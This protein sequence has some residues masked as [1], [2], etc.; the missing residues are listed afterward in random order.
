MDPAAVY[1]KT[2][3]GR[4]EMRV[5][6]LALPAR[7]RALLIA[8]DG[9]HSAAALARQFPG[10][11][12]IGAALTQ[13]H[14]LGLVEPA[15]GSQAPRVALP[16][17]SAIQAPQLEAIADVAGERLERAVAFLETA[18]RERMGRDAQ[19]FTMRL[20]LCASLRHVYALIPEV[21]RI[22]SRR[23]GD[24]VADATVAQLIELLR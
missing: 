9:R 1:A 11:T 21:R 17:A 15:P 13:L 3:R 12:D 5:R 22:L 18:A 6:S 2:E 8:T 19:R 14:A 16:L 10:L 24:A 4:E 7:L 23:H 20:G